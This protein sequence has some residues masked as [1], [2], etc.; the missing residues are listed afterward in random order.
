MACRPAEALT[1]LAVGLP[2]AASAVRFLELLEPWPAAYS[3]SL[4]SAGYCAMRAAA[5][6]FDRGDSIAQRGDLAVFGAFHTFENILELI[7]FSKCSHYPQ[8]SIERALHGL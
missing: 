2:D 8:E 4:L 1:P 7:M 6:R 5:V 3:A